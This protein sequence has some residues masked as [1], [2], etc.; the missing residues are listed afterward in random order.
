MVSIPLKT[1]ATERRV[2]ELLLEQRRLVAAL[3]GLREQLR[4]SLF[5][6]WG[7]CGKA[8]CACRSG[9][10]HG[11]YYVLSTRSAGKGAFTYL[12]HEQVT[13]ARRLVAGFRRFRAGVRR[14]RSLN[15][16]LLRL[17]G[18]YQKAA[19]Q[20]APRRLGLGLP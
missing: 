16:E 15:R 13:R 14:L 7:R 10:P 19:A 6:R 18:R 11:P 12:A 1:H 17:L 20:T 9:R 3:L 8:G 2:R 5:T 4:G